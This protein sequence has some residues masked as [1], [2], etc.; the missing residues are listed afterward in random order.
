M[1]RIESLRARRLLDSR[2]DATVEIDVRAGPIHARAAAPSGAS[3][4]SHEVAPWPKGGVAA[5]LSAIPKVTAKLSGVDIEDQEGV[6][7]RLHEIDGTANF[8]GI[9]GNLAV[10]VSLACARGGAASKGVPLFR[11]WGTPGGMPRPQG[12]VLGGGRHAVGGTTI[13]EFM[14][15]AEAP[16]VGDAVFANARVHR[17]VRDRLMKDHPG[18]ALGKGDEAAWVAPM[19]DMQALRLVSEECAAATKETGVLCRPSLDVAATEFHKA[20]T[21]QYRDRAL[22][23]D[24]QIDFLVSLVEDFS[25]A[26]LEDPL[27]EEDFSGF[28]ELTKRVGKQCLIVGD[29]LFATSTP[30]LRRGL[31]EGAANA[32]LIKPNQCGTV[33]DTRAC[34]DLAHRGGYKTVMSHRSG[35]TTD[36]SIA[37]LAV[38]FGCWGIKT[39]AVGGER[40][41]K[42]NE[43][44]RIEEQMRDDGS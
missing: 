22:S 43:L 26:S 5:S 40:I 16:S 23:R 35:E 13:Q 11:R 20:G 36:D 39:G 31:E 17:R 25:L 41:A 28:A 33:T 9:G 38:A 21:Y 18:I 27:E 3:T 34:V 4:G 15:T 29:D 32:V 2:G 1:P 30:R 8:S 7:A 37:H 10:A 42:L 19:E 44:I 14:S 12:N 6:D 24:A